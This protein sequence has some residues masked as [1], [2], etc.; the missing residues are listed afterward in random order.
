VRPVSPVNLLLEADA[1]LGAV[2]A[3]GTGG[4]IGHVPAYALLDPVAPSGRQPIPPGILTAPRAVVLGLALPCLALPLCCESTRPSSAVSPPLPGASPRLASTTAVLATA[5]GLTPPR[6]PS[7]G[8]VFGPS[9][10]RSSD[11]QRAAACGR[12]E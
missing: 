1:C 9:L 4:G 2:V 3:G 6:L 7:A 11:V 10:Q 5:G 8:E 12:L